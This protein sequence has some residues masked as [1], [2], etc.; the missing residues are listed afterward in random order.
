MSL[1]HLAAAFWAVHTFSF[2]CGQKG[3]SLPALEQ[4]I[5]LQAAWWLLRI[6]AFVSLFSVLAMSLCTL[7]LGR[8]FMF[9]GY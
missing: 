4:P 8:Y 2:A 7:F 3:Q 9:L 6:S 5:S 1:V